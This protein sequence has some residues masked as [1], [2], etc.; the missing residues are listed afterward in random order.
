MSSD[1]KSAWSSEE[2]DDPRILQGGYG[3]NRHRC[4][5]NRHPHDR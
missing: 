5:F 1:I 3:L 2:V 4:V